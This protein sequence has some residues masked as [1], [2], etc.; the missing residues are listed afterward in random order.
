MVLHKRVSEYDD[1]L[2]DLRSKLKE[3]RPGSEEQV[4]LA[5]SIKKIEEAKNNKHHLSPDTVFTGLISL[6]GIGAILF[7]EGKDIFLGGSKA[8]MFINKPK[9]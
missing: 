3:A 8:W 7:V 6:A 9:F 4:N 1:I 5:R 2:E